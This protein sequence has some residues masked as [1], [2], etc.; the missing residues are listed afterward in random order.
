MIS[1]RDVLID[2]LPDG[3]GGPGD[4]RMRRAQAHPCEFQAPPTWRRQQRVRDVDA[5]T[6]SRV[7]QCLTMP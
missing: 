3:V 7:E 5:L 6:E 2:S 4:S 1:L